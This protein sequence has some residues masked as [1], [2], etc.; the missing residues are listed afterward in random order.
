MAAAQV[1]MPGGHNP[2]LRRH[3]GLPTG[4]PPIDLAAPKI[5]QTATFALG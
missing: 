2:P 5:T 1:S 4:L 3:P